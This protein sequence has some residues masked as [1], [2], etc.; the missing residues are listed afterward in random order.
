MLCLVHLS[1]RIIARPAAGSELCMG[2]PTNVLAN[3]RDQDQVEYEGE[4][5][6]EETTEDEEEE[7]VEQEVELPPVPAEVRLCTCMHKYPFLP[8]L[9]RCP[10]PLMH[11]DSSVW[12]W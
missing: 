9:C 1:L 12:V 8:Q 2:T 10:P 7:V 11:K 5:E 3:F 4:E 6:E